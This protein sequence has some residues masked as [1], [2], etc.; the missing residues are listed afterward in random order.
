MQILFKPLLG[1][2]LLNIIAKSSHLTDLGARLG[3]HHKVTGQ[4]VWLSEGLR[5][6]VI[7][8]T[9]LQ[10][11][12]CPKLFKYFHIQNMHKYILG[13]P[14]SHPIMEASLKSRFSPSTPGPDVVSFCAETYKL[15][16]QAACFHIP[17]ILFID[18]ISVK[19]QKNKRAA[20]MLFKVLQYHFCQHPIGQS[21]SC[22][23]TQGESGGH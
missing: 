18:C 20:Q 17:H 10:L 7:F 9:R 4:M 19:M 21:K 11:S 22:D 23:Q 15:K 8:F 2:Y 13:P 12:L 14:K 6:V 5:I 1:S 3:E 16:R